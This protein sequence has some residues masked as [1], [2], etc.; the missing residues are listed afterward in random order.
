MVAMSV[1]VFDGQFSLSCFK[2]DC[3]RSPLVQIQGL[4]PIKDS[5]IPTLMIDF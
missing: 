2:Y 3:L 4:Y 1:V 5:D